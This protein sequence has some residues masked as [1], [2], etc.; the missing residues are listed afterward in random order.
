MHPGALLDPVQSPAD[1]VR[2]G[3]RELAVGQDAIGVQPGYL[4]RPRHTSKAMQTECPCGSGSPYEECCGPFINNARVATTA[5]Q[6]M[7]SRYS[8]FVAGDA[9]Y[10]LKTWHTSKRPQQLELDPGIEWRRLQIREVTGGSPTD[11]TGTVEFIA[12][13]WDSGDKQYGRHHEVSRFVRQ[14]CRWL[15]VEPLEAHSGS[16]HDATLRPG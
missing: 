6:L 13:Y 4:Q 8:A 1:H 15:Y 2:P 12:H 9:G 3:R 14:K 10:L 5:E 11:D 16:G 7:R